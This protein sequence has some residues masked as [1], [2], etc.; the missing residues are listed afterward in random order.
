MSN[1]RSTRPTVDSIGGYTIDAVLEHGSLGSRAA[2]RTRSGVAVIVEAISVTAEEELFERALRRVDV[3]SR[4]QHDHLVPL[5]DAGLEHDKFFMVT[6]Q[7]DT[8]ATE[9]PAMGNAAEEPLVAVAQGLQHL[10]NNRILHRDIQARHIGW[11]DGVTKL[12][13]VGLA[14]SLSDE[15][16]NGVG[17]IGAISTMAPSIV[18]GAPATIGSDVYSLG[19]TLH[20][21]ATGHGVFA[22][23]TESLAKR[24][25]RIATESPQI[26]ASLSHELRDTVGQM[27]A[28]DGLHAEAHALL[29]H[30]A[31][32]PE[33]NLT[34]NLTPNL[35]RETI[36]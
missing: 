19:A 16:T 15:R 5:L 32:Q 36:S 34:P 6:P 23:R 33:H 20:L 31:R 17:P 18:N 3:M 30:F 29:T 22:E 25:V 11:Y 7:P 13:G 27:L 2:A 8:V 24:I 10:H 26:H 28:V 4:V 21:L 9:L 35:T 1:A 12:G 14:D